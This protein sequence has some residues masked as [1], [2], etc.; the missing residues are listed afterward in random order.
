MPILPD[1]SGPPGSVAGTAGQ[2][3]KRSSAILEVL[4]S[5]LGLPIVILDVS[6]G[7]G[8]LFPGPP[9]GPEDDSTE[10]EGAGPDDVLFFLCSSFLSPAHPTSFSAPSACPPSAAG[11]LPCPPVCFLGQPSEL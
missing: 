1:R 11:S 10:V 3:G 8:L 5:L 4:A 7:R 9:G 2:Y 6:M